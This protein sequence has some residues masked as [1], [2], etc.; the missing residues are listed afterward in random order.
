MRVSRRATRFFMLAT[1]VV[2]AVAMSR[3]GG[4][5][6]PTVPSALAVASVSLNAASITIGGTGQGTVTLTAAA[7]GGATVPLSSSNPSVAT[8]Q[9][10]VT[11]PAGSLSAAFTVTAVAPGT[12]TITAS[13]SGSTRQ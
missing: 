13:L 11:V 1:T 8:V 2:A 5:S 9:T 4:S 7:P 12:A 3:C 6:S 10:P